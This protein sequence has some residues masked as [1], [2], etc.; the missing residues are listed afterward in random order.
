MTYASTRG[1]ITE[2]LTESGYLVDQT[3]VDDG[4]GGLAAP[5]VTPQLYTP[6]VT[7]TQLAAGVYTQGSSLLQADNAAFRYSNALMR[8]IATGSPTQLGTAYA[9]RDR[10][11]P[12]TSAQ[13]N[14]WAVEFDYTGTTLEVHLSVASGAYYWFW[15]DD[16]A[17]SA[18]PARAPSPISGATFRILQLN[19]GSSA[20]RKIRIEGQ[21]VNAIFNGVRSGSGVLAEACEADRLPILAWVGDSYGDGRKAT[22]ELMGFVRTLGRLRNLEAWQFPSYGGQG[23]VYE[24]SAGLKHISR[25]ATDLAP[26]MIVIQGSINDSLGSWSGNVGPAMVAAIEQAQTDFPNATIFATSPLFASTPTSTVRSIAAEIEAAVAAS[27]PS[28]SYIDAVEWFTN[29]SGAYLD[30]DGNHPNQDGHDA[31]A[32]RMANEIAYSGDT[33]ACRI[34]SM[35]GSEGEVANRISDRSTHLLTLPPGSSVTTEDQFYVIGRGTYEVTAVREHTGEF[36]TVFEAVEF[37]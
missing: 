28:V 11:A 31:F 16:R 34:D 35:S 4:G 19:L 20:K 27:A 6:T 8:S 10:V 23:L 12:T 33:I 5:L 36:S 17:I 37:A 32:T 13:G 26:E 3:A 18:T 7:I 15:V 25:M 2:A 22:N 29:T 14:K 9:A 21:G 24:S 1:L 30:A